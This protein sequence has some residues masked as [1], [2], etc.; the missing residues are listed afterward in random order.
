MLSASHR[1]AKGSVSAL[2]A[3]DPNPTQVDENGLGILDTLGS[4]VLLTR[5]ATLFREGDAAEFYYKVVSGAVRSCKLLADGR[6]HITDFFL[7]GDFIGVEALNTHGTTAE[8]V[9]D[10]TVVRYERGMIDALVSR[11][12]RVGRFLL[13]RVCAELSEARSRMLL[14]GRMSARERL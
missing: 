4:V 2:A 11:S 6:R 5:D 1:D 13:G 8:A 7:A 3:A 10:A 9:N 14:L 12:P